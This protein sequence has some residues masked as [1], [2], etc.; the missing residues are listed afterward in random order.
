MTTQEYDGPA[1]VVVDGH[2]V[3]AHARLSGRFEPIS[4]RYQWGGRLDPTDELAALLRPNIVVRLHTGEHTGDRHTAEAT[5]RE[6]DP[7]GG[8]RVS[9]AGRPP[10]AV[11]AETP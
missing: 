9:G 3:A 4:G 10:F 6:V 1:R 11:P 5:V 2:V 7:W 8:F